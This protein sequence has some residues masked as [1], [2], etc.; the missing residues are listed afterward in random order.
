M[1]KLLTFDGANSETFKMQSSFC[2]QA[3]GP[4]FTFTYKVE[5]LP[6]Q[7]PDDSG[8]WTDAVMQGTVSTVTDAHR[9]A[10]PLTFLGMKYRVVRS[11]TSTETPSIYVGVSTDVQHSFAKNDDI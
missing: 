5:Q 9:I 8:L 1:A 7:L 2:V 10:V 4:S 3:I 6:E 11:G